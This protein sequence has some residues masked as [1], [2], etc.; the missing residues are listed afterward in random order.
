MAGPWEKYAQS[1][2]AQAQE[3]PWMKYGGST[4]SKAPNTSASM[5]AL[6][7]YG[8]AAT[9]GYLP[10]IQAATS[11]LMPNPNAA[12]DEKLRAQGFNVQN[13]EQSYV[14]ARDQNIRRQQLQA[15][16]HPV[17]SATGT[18]GGIVGGGVLTGG[19]GRLA[20]LGKAATGVGRIKEAAKA[21]AVIGGL[22]NPGD[23]EGELRPIQV[24]ERA[25][26]AAIGGAVGVAAQGLVEGVGSGV[27][28]VGEY[29]RSKAE[30]R[31]FK[32]LGPDLR[33][34]RQNMSRDQ[35]EKIGRTLLDSG[36]VKSRHSREKIADL[37]IRAK[38][39]KGKEL[40]G[41]IRELGEAQEKL[42][43]SQPGLVKFGS[44]TTSTRAG[45]DRKQIAQ[46]VRDELINPDTEIPNTV[47]KN[48]RIERLI[49]EFENGGDDLI[50][51]LRGENLK[52]SVGGEIK[53]DR[54]P[55]ADIPLEEQVQRSLYSKL[56]Q[57]TEDAAEAVEGIVGGPGAGRFKSAKNAYGNLSE[58]EKVIEKRLER[59]LANRFISPSDYMTGGLGA[60]AGFASGDSPEEKL[61]NAAL[62]AS[63][64]A[65]NRFGRNYGNQISAKVGDTIA[66]A[67]LKIPQY[68]QM[69]TKNP[70]GFQGVVQRVWERVQSKGAQPLVPANIANKDAPK[71][72]KGE[73]RWANKGI[74]NLGITD[75]HLQEKLLK[76]KEGRGLLIEAS[77]L[78]PDSKRL[79]KIKEKIQKG[80]G[81]NELS[82]VS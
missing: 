26:N 58:A 45:I 79:Q 46:A 62:G 34:V 6:E 39:A 23:I 56:R 11:K 75:E 66:K 50:P 53:W 76:S 69:A 37:V 41:I 57:G 17:A 77:D 12:L 38:D 48:R 30:R 15:K 80:W 22:A 64:G 32:A 40:E 67:L 18:V 47:R 20:G 44:P 1:G 71:E 78:K 27:K 70:A 9:L 74:G 4:E 35:V 81:S 14:D 2:S 13:A 16:E 28:K 54:L 72:L 59:D 82:P 3:G 61:R 29:V 31:A 63:L 65:V 5:A 55:G 25:K 49:K 19:L 21:G 42:F 36:V 24:E 8:N 43:A 51:I 73:A 10:H 52:K 33:A 68:S 7:S 60:A